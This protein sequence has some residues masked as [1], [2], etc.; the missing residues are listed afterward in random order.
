MD[1][2]SGREK[3]DS[4]STLKEQLVAF[5]MCWLWCCELCFS[6]SLYFSS[7]TAEKGRNITKE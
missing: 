5:T 2:S 4:R 7:L 3:W 6:T 1:G